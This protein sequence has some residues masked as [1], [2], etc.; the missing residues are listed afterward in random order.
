MERTQPDGQVLTRAV[1]LGTFFDA[2][3]IDS[4]VVDDVSVLLFGDTAVVRGRTTASGTLNLD[5][6]WGPWLPTWEGFAGSSLGLSA[7]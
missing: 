7:E 6:R 4:N 1:V 3:T 5:L 2:V